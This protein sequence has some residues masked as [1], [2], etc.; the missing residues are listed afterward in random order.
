VPKRGMITAIGPL[1]IRPA[2]NYLIVH[3]LDQLF[4]S[5]VKTA[6]SAH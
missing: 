5:P 4:I 1:L 3:P 6:N 2:M